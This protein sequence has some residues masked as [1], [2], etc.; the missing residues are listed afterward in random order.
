[1]VYDMAVRSTF[2]IGITLM[3]WSRLS[4]CKWQDISALKSRNGEEWKG[5]ERGS[6]KVGNTVDVIHSLL[7]KCCWNMWERKGI[8]QEKGG[9]LCPLWEEN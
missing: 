4:A 1:M 9:Q 5:R 6:R 2:M 3:V 8:L 7:L